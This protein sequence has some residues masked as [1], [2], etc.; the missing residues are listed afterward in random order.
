MAAR[1]ARLTRSSDF[2]RIYREGSSTASRFLVLYSFKQSQTGERDEPRLGLSVSKKLGGAVVRNRVKRLLREG[3][4]ACEGRLAR[5]PRLRADRPSAARRAARRATE[6]SGAASRGGAVR[7]GRTARGSRRLRLMSRLFIVMIRAYQVAISPLLGARCRYYPT[8]SNYAIEALR[9]HGVAARRRPGDVASS[10]AATRSAPAASI[11]C[12]RRAPGGRDVDHL[13]HSLLIANF[14]GD[15]FRPLIDAPAAGCSRRSR[16]GP[17]R[18]PSW[19]R[20]APGASRSSCS[21]CWCAR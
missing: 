14:L 11:T 12:R 16:A 5:R 15:F 1:R 6:G 19:P 9:V 17:R 10:C 2:Q 13:L 7:A 4:R 21:P 3:F 18:S 8:C 20:S